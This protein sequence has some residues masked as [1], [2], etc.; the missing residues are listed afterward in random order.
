[1]NP[2]TREIIRLLMYQVRSEQHARAALVTALAR[3]EA[4][5][6]LPVSDEELDVRIKELE[7]MVV[8]NKT[9]TNG[10]NKSSI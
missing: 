1:M 10:V 9:L 5:P 7:E 6:I 8:Q 3:E 4:T 2:T